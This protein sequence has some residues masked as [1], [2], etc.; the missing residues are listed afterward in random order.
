MTRSFRSF[1][2]I[3]TPRTEYYYYYYYY[4]TTTTTINIIITITITI[5]II[6]IV[7]IIVVVV[8]LLFIIYTINLSVIRHRSCRVIY[9]FN[10]PALGRKHQSFGRVNWSLFFC[11]VYYFFVSVLGVS[12]FCSSVFSLLFPPARSPLPSL[13]KASGSLGGGNGRPSKCSD[14]NLVIMWSCNPQSRLRSDPRKPKEV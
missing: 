1:S 4:T 2:G 8:V 13:Y 11:W 6:V 7:I 9:Y 14:T 5:I 12:Y 10:T 3:T